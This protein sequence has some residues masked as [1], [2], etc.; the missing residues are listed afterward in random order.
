[1]MVTQ[2]RQKLIV[3]AVLILTAG[4][5][6]WWWS[7]PPA[8]EFDN[9]RYIQLLTTAISSRNPE[10]VAKVE[11]AIHDRHRDGKMSDSELGHFDKL[12]TLA[13]DDQ[14]EAADRACFAFAESQL[15]RSRHRPA[16]K[17]DHDH[18]HAH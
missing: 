4:V 7:R 11:L 18:G 8:V 9:L 5:G 17:K 16:E 1:M 2:H 6:W 15:S 12:I 13:R 3:A 14:W 10:L